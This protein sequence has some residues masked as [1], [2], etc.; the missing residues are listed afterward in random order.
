MSPADL[1]AALAD[2]ATETRRQALRHVAEL[3]GGRSDYR[4]A[5]LAALADPAWTVREEAA[6]TAGVLRDPDGAI[7]R[8]LVAV[9]LTD[10]KPHVRRAAAEAAGPR[11]QPERDFGAAVRHRFERQRA[12]G[13]L[14]VGHAP[15]GLEGAALELLRLALA[16]SHPKV[17]RAALLGL[18]LLPG[19]AART[20]LPVV[21]RKCAEAEPGVAAAARAVWAEL[22]HPRHWDEPLGPLRPFAG[23][24]YAAGLRLEVEALPADHPLRRAWES[25][26][27]GWRGPADPRGFARL[28]SRLCERVL[29]DGR[30]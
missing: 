13:A 21:A 22:L 5:V 14:A 25:R 9:S 20:L 23:G 26:P 19:Q 28:L 8:A 3:S 27:E 1:R 17:R 18:A 16:D 12:R 6:R 15:P 10:P 11:M 29:A 2:P 4:E 24:T 7:L 30:R